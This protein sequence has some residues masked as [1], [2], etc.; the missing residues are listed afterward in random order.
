MNEINKN[1]TRCLVESGRYP[2]IIE[3]LNSKMK[4]MAVK[5]VKDI[6]GEGL[7][8]SKYYIDDFD[9]RW[10]TVELRRLKVE[11]IDRFHLMDELILKLGDKAVLEKVIKN[12]SNYDLNTIKEIIESV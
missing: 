7:K 1:I 4:L 6:S 10:I 9:P 2:E 8:D 11:K 12:L 5:L 3:C